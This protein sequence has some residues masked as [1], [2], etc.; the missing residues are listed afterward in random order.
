MRKSQ[1]LRHLKHLNEE[2]L[3]NELTQLYDKLA[4]VKQYYSME[5]GSADERK[6]IYDRAKKEISSKYATKSYR[7]PRRPRIQKINKILSDM[8]K[9]S[10]FTH[11]LIDLYL[12]DV[13]T[14]LVFMRTYGFFSE[15]LANHIIG[16]Y[17]KALLLAEG[18]RLQEELKTRCEE[19]LRSSR[20]SLGINMD[21]EELTN[22]FMKNK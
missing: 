4:E 6:K 13:E 7:K 17:Q 22:Q 21:L 11:E 10:V 15:V 1:F 14:A 8:A 16:V 3:R 9:K 19:I 12:Y 5:L 20:Y 18:L 2:E